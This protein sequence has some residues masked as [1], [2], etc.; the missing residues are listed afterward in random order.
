MKPW[1][2][3]KVL[4]TNAALAAGV[5]LEAHFSLVKDSLR[6][7]WYLTGMALIAAINAGLRWYTTQ[8]IKELTEGDK[9]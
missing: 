1:Y 3:S 4:W 9:K 2:K 5:A 7:H 6:P 8:P